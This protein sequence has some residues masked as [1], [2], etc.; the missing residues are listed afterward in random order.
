[1]RASTIPTPSARPG[2]TDGEPKKQIPDL[3]EP[4]ARLAWWIRRIYRLEGDDVVRYVVLALRRGPHLR[5]VWPPPHGRKIVQSG[6]WDKIPSETVNW[7]TGHITP[8]PRDDPDNPPEQFSIEAEWEAVIEAVSDWQRQQR[9]VAAYAAR[10]P[11][12]GVSKEA[13]PEPTPDPPRRGGG[14]R[15]KYDWPRV[16]L[17]L[18]LKLQDD[19]A[20]KE[21]DGGQAELERF[22]ASL[23]P[24]DNCPSASVIREWVSGVIE[25]FRRDL[26]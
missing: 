15:A 5:I 9:T 4:L 25:A 11:M 14:R 16:T 18:L 8:G 7:D 13:S 6:E 2:V 19:G 24:S 17:K 10:A 26:G 23:F 1:M 21:G 20:P 12:K 3:W 22:A